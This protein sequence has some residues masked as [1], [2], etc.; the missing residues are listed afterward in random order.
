MKIKEFFGVLSFI[1]LLCLL[2]L[3]LT[4]AISIIQLIPDRTVYGDKQVMVFE[5]NI[6]ALGKIEGLP[7]ADENKRLVFI[8]EKFWYLPTANSS[9]SIGEFFSLSL[10]NTVVLSS[11]FEFKLN[12]ESP[13]NNI[14]G[15][16]LAEI[17]D[18]DNKN[19]GNGLSTEVLYFKAPYSLPLSQRFTTS[20]PV[21]FKMILKTE[22]G[23]LTRYEKKKL[24][25][26]KKV[27][28]TFPEALVNHVTI[29]P[30][31]EELN[32]IYSEQ[33]IKEKQA[34]E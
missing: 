11:P 17:K 8:G 27:Q 26:Q 31:S 16:V 18:Q 5:D 1:L 2:G 29:L 3:F 32:F 13:T 7:N 22:D 20:I 15:Y 14:V 33:Y 23:E 19:L 28:K 30:L 34:M 25:Q 4:V 12:Q 6:I 24:R 21:T 9:Y 10:E